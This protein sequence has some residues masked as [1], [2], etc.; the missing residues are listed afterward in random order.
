MRHQGH[1]YIAEVYGAA[2]HYAFIRV[3]FVDG[4]ILSN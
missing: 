2:L 4:W 3:L 1:A